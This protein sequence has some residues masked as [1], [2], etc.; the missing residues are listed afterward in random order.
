MV[1]TG[2]KR[3]YL[4]QDDHQTSQAMR[5]HY[6]IRQRHLAAGASHTPPLRGSLPA[7]SLLVTGLFVVAAAAFLFNFC[8]VGEGAFAHGPVKGVELVTATVIGARPPAA[9]GLPAEEAAGAVYLSPALWVV[10]AFV[11]ATAGITALARDGVNAVLVEIISGT[12]GIAA[13]TMLQWAITRRFPAYQTSF[14]AG[15][16]MAFAAFAA[17]TGISGVALWSR[18]PG[19]LGEPPSTTIH[20][21]IISRG[22]EAPPSE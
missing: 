22:E 11:A 7:A 16:W 8:E 9:G 19:S 12:A 5:D 3:R 2:S 15:Y 18:A 14:L 1:Y 13:L 21:S 20:I 6:L 10:L 4:R 17:A